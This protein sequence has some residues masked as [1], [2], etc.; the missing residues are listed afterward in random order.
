MAIKLTKEDEKRLAAQRAAQQ[1]AQPKTSVQPET[2]A[3]SPPASTQTPHYQPSASVTAAQDY[4][5]KVKEGGYDKQWSTQLD[6]LANEYMGRGAFEYDASSD[7]Q[8]QQAKAQGLA[9][10]DL[11]M[12][13]TMAQAAALSGGYGN[14][15]AQTVGQQVYQQGVAD[16]MA[17]APEYYQAAYQRYKD[18]GDRMLQ[19]ISLAQSMDE[20][21]YARYADALNRAQAEYDAAY[22]RDY[23][24][25]SDQRAYDYQAGRDAVADERYGREWQYQLDRDAIEDQRYDTEWQYQKDRDDVAD[26]RYDTEWQYQLDRDAVEDQRYASELQYQRDR[27]AVEDA[28]YDAEKEYRAGRDKIE[29]ER[30]NAEW[31]YQK[32]RDTL[33]DDYNELKGQYDTLASQVEADEKAIAAYTKVIESPKFA[34]AL[35]T[36][37]ST[38]NGPTPEGKDLQSV[39]EA[40]Y[41][42]WFAGEFGD[43]EEA[44]LFVEALADEY[45]I[46]P[47]DILGRE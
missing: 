16:V 24:E 5:K 18:E 31:E 6:A 10:A 42:M 47:M 38:T 28:R 9:G 13:D 23:G 3:A 43:G 36:I 30:Y 19:D 37:E 25:F 35:E 34:R 27:D 12:R 2:G 17:M 39:E 4:L 22:A 46:D 20:A 26:S 15:Y 21:A 41:N 11:A 7:V 32:E 44:K 1:T 29:D 14:S 40:I 8:W 33:E 45:G